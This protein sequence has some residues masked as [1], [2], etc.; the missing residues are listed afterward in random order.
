MSIETLKIPGID[1]AVSRIALGTWA[2]GGRLWGGSD[3]ELSIKTL[4]HALASGINLIDTAPV[5]GFGLS[6]ELIGKALRG[7]RHTAVIATKAGLQWD[8]GTTRR[9][10]TAQRIRKE[11]EDSLVRLETDY[12]DLYQIHWPDPLVAQEETADELERLRR[13]GK[14]LAVGVSNY[15]PA[16]MDDF[17]RYTALATVQPPYN[18]FER[19]IDSDILPYAKNHGLVVLAYGSLCRGLLTGS[20]HSATSF[21]G[22][23]VRRIDPKFKAPRFEQYL[24]AVGALEVYARECHGKSILALALRWVLDQGPT[25]ALWGAR[26]PEQLKGYEEAFGWHLTADDLTHIDRIL[27]STIKDPIGP[28]FMAPAKR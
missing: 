21:G 15:S 23:D 8:D 1:K 2:M 17:S 3:N 27:A 16:Q 22:D 28:E 24:A 13:E 6:E 4:R 7:V 25:I 10:A 20:M 14:I 9:N 11:V 18:L 5:Y 12:I 19:A 26:R